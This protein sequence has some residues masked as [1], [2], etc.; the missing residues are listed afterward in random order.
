MERAKN[1]IIKI[2]FL[3]SVGV[4]FLASS[5]LSYG[6]TYD[7]AVSY[8]KF[9]DLSYDDD[10]TAPAIN[11]DRWNPLP[12]AGC[13][14]NIT[15][16]EA[17]HF[18]DADGTNKFNTLRSNLNISGDFDIQVDW[19]A[20]NFPNPTIGQN[21]ISLYIGGQST[22][23]GSNYAQ[24]RT[25]KTSGG[26]VYQFHWRNDGPGGS[27]SSIS[28]SD[29]A[30]KFRVAR[31]G[32]TLSGYFWENGAWR[33]VGSLTDGWTADVIAIDQRLVTTNGAN[34]DLTA[35]F[36]NFKIVEGELVS[37]SSGSNAG[38]IAGATQT[39][40]QFGNALNFDGVDDYVE[41]SDNSSP[42][43]NATF[44]T[45]VKLD[46]TSGDNPIFTQRYDSPYHGR[47]IN[48]VGG[49][50]KV[51]SRDS[52]HIHN[53]VY[54]TDTPQAG[55]WYHTVLTQEGNII[56]GYLDGELKG[57]LDMGSNLGGRYLG[58]FNMGKYTN[59]FYYLD[60]DIDDVGIWDR[61]L[62]AYEI[63][64]IY[65][66]GT[67]KFEAVSMAL[68]NS[69]DLDFTTEEISQ[70]ATLYVAEE[71]GVIGGMNFTYYSGNLPGD[72][73]GEVYAIG[74]SWV[75]GGKYYIKLGSGFEFEP[76]PLGGVPELP[77]FA[78][79]LMVIMLGG[80]FGFIKRRV[81]R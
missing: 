20:I 2:I 63:A 31:E 38:V 3:L 40:G 57:T 19:S 30:G 17:R 11:T 71:S 34:Y 46:T 81:T 67:E 42:Q 60:G 16:G 33:K 5:T 6:A 66:L 25:E 69:W 7:E 59:A 53:H 72:T 61:A 13:S 70:L 48:L 28:T 35:S 65:G 50:L 43:A 77:P 37:D 49:Y 58:Y 12:P 24:M 68:N 9:D 8:W 18:V 22:A 56:K 41:I 78:M 45:W 47:G 44:S 76:V 29:T 21:D 64:A 80:A 14:I 15:S 32:S 4:I 52:A 10:F 79:Q 55:V 26:Q 73:D 54:L 23:G 51:W 75:D 74:D 62:D 1:N 36:D 27:V 39:T